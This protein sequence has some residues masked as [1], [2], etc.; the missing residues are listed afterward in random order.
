MSG[1]EKI[2]LGLTGYDELFMTD[3]GRKE[4]RLP[5]IYDIPLEQID[6]FPNHP[7]KVRI[8]EDMEQLVESVRERGIITPITLRQKE[9]GRYELVSGHRR[10]K[11]CELAGLTMVKAK[12]IIVTSLLTD[13]LHWSGFR[14]EKE[15]IYCGDS[16]YYYIGTSAHSCSL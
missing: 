6:D 3:E 16:Y 5:R 12:I 14:Y 10:K 4:N 8:D 2:N 9:N 13:F 15:S 7:F 1:K 11:A